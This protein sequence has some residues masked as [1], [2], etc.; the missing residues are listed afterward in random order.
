MTKIRSEKNCLI[1][2]IGAESRTGFEINGF[3]AKKKKERRNPI[4][5]SLRPYSENKGWRRREVSHN[6]KGDELDE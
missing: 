4:P 3:F 5:T 6:L 2:G 1:L